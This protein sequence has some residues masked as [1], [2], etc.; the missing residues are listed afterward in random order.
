MVFSCTATIVLKMLWIYSLPVNHWREKKKE[1]SFIWG[2]T[3][4]CKIMTGT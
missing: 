2:I 4:A 1:E 3:E